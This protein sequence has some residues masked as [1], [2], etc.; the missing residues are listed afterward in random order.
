MARS[1]PVALYHYISKLAN[2]ISVHPDT[3]ASHLKA[4]ERGGFRGIG[5]DEAVDFLA[6]GKDLPKGAALLSFDD[7]FLDNYVHA[8]P[9]L[10]ER[11]H[12]GVVFA[13]TDRIGHESPRP[14]LADVRDND[15]LAKDLPHVD[16]PFGLNELGHRRRRDLFLS[17]P[18]ARRMEESGVMAVE[19][20]TASHAEV[21]RADEYNGFFQPGP[22]SRTFDRV[23]FPVPWGLPRFATGPGLTTRAFLPSEELLGLVHSLVPQDKAGAHDFFRDEANVQRLRRKMEALPRSRWGRKEEPG[24]FAE[25]VREEVARSVRTVESELGRPARALAWPWGAYSPEALEAA[26][27][28]GVEA[29]FCTTTGPNPPG[30]PLHVHRFKARQ[31]SGL[32]LLSRL[33][34]WSRPWLGGAYARLKR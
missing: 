29:M 26:R 15:A 7:G 6:R 2:A 21:F 18:E 11:G 34:I 13:V 28:C 32:W 14:T 9:I 20:H 30:S 19:P 10:A 12:K 23:G 4:M 1:L 3:F 27:E 22:R 24:E 25:R 17:W 33:H 8:W 31:R 16:E 5:L